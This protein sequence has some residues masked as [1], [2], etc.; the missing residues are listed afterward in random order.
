MEQRLTLRYTAPP[1]FELTPAA[2]ARLEETLL[3]IGRR[4]D[5]D[6]T[7]VALP[8]GLPDVIIAGYGFEDYAVSLQLIHRQLTVESENAAAAI[9]VYLMATDT[10]LELQPKGGPRHD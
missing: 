1:C 6:C 2:M 3:E 9:R 5:A 8:Q 7:E 10:P 4:L